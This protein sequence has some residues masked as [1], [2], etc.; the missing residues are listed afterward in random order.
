MHILLQNKLK[1]RNLACITKVDNPE[2]AL[3]KFEVFVSGSG[4]SAAQQK[5]MAGTTEFN[6]NNF[7]SISSGLGDVKG[8]CIV[9]DEEPSKTKRRSAQDTTLPSIA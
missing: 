5:T 3:K 8:I 6:E 9:L 4:D 1:P 2:D 7:D